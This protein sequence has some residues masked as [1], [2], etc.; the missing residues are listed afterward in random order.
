MGQ[1]VEQGCIQTGAQLTAPPLPR[2]QICSA[3]TSHV[4]QT[5]NPTFGS[6]VLCERS[7]RSHGILWEVNSWL[8]AFLISL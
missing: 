3:L 2:Q 1:Q 8:H 7:E 5:L 6:E 4:P